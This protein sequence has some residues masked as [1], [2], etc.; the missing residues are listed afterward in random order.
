[1]MKIQL[2]RLQL[3]KLKFNQRNL[4]RKIDPANQFKTFNPTINTK[5]FN[6]NSQNAPNKNRISQRL[7]GRRTKRRLRKHQRHLDAN[8]SHNKT[9]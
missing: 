6:E 2:Q 4:L 3:I 9:I 7:S 8:I 5:I 1:M